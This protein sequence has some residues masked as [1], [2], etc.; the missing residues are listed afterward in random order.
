METIITAMSTAFTSLASSLT[1]VISG[2]V[3]VAIP[4]FGLLMAVRVGMRTFK[5]A[6]AV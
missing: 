5:T 6:A 2:I 4:L 3:P 1:S